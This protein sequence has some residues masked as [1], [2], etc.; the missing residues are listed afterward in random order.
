MKIKNLTKI[1]VILTLLFLGNFCYAAELIP[2]DPDFAKQWYLTHLHLPNVWP[3]ETGATNVV[4]AVIDSGVDISH[5]DLRDNI[6]I[7]RDEIIGDNI[8]NDHNGYIDDGEGWDFVAGV[9]DPR[10]KFESD[11]FATETCSKEAIIHG[12]LV[13]GIIAAIGN[14]NYGTTGITWNVKIMPLRVLNEIGSGNTTDVVRAI[15]YAIDNGAA[16]INLSFVGDTYDASLE[17]AIERAYL[18][19]VLVI[20]AAGNESSG[21]L[22]TNMDVTKMYPVC[23][24][25][26]NMEN[27]IIGVAALDQKDKLSVFSNFGSSCVDVAAPGENIYGLLYHDEK[28]VELINYFGGYYSGTSLAAPIVAGVAALAKASSPS[29]SGKEI[30]DLILKNADNI[31]LA[32]PDLVGKLGNGLIDP[33]KIFSALKNTNFNPLI[34]GSTDTVYYDGADGKRYSFPDKNTYLSWHDNFNNVKKISDSDL[35][36]I[37]FGGVVNYRPGSLLKITTVPNVYA[38]AHDGVLRWITSEELASM[39]YG[40]NWQSLVRDIP[41]SFFATYKMGDPLSIPTTFD[42][43]LERNTYSTIDLDKGL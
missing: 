24:Q 14:N 6:W 13:A 33:V 1:L 43:V 9:S 27:I 10:P 18:N 29:L 20:G 3:M 8:D 4:V 28:I 7:N 40:A 41:D 42:P 23:S 15:N 36:M 16:I 2:N 17:K 21:G 32:N 38:V 26:T 35:A 19:G 25:G 37:P 39:L 11:C 34:K 5:P 31:D 30:E 12:T 22:P